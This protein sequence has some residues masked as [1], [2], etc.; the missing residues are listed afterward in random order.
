M[1]LQTVLLSW[2]AVFALTLHAKTTAPEES[3]AR[4]SAL[5]GPLFY[6]ILLGE[7]NARDE[8]PGNA[9]SLLLDAAR[10][11][12]DPELFKRSVRIALQA[13][14]GQSALQAARAW[15]SAMPASQ[16]ANRYLLQILLGLNRVADTLDP[17]KKEI[18]LS[19]IAERRELIWALPSL[20]ERVQDKPAAA[21]LM[22]KALVNALDQPYL[23]ATAWAALG[24]MWQSAGDSA[25]A[26]NAAKEA[27]AQDV[28]SEHAALLALALMNAGVADA[29]AL[30]ERHLPDARSEF[31]MAYVKS[32]LNARREDDARSQ[33][34][35]I[36][37]KSPAYPDAWLVDGA[38]LVQRG[39]T[40]LAEQ[41]LQ[42]YLELTGANADTHAGGDARRGRSQAFLAMAQ[43]AQQRQDLAKAQDW[44]QKVDNPDDVL[45]AQVSRAS[46]MAKQGRIDDAITLIREHVERSEADAKLKR[47]AEVQLLREQ[48]LFARARDTLK[49]FI[50]Q[51][52]S[53]TDLVYQLAMVYEKLGDLA[54]MEHLLRDL[55]AAQPDDPHA[56][57]AL[58]YSLAD[59]NLRL[60]EAIKLI[61][62]ALELAPKDPFITD[63]LAWA[64]FRSGNNEE[65]LRL[66]QQAYGDRQ[67]AEIAAHLGEVLWQMGQ[68][69]A[70]LKIFRES[71]KTA[72]DNATLTD[73]LKRLHVPL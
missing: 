61:T 36:E 16:E 18:S 47:S 26:L 4:I 64:H 60:P 30:V 50:A 62:K 29:E 42:R 56:Y 11:T 41:R 71:Q 17:L 25:A 63:S 8:E 21:A 15:S 58:G 13:R 32:L 45:R 24:R 53:D 40:D 46:L 59:R 48:N 19:P 37:D 72:P 54:E 70:A 28:Q 31:R 44:L 33:L 43:V 5:D 20:Y 3:V 7:L 34:Q 67:D 73:T 49:T 6:Q 23:S 51:F 12:N 14:S 1:R 27:Q 9:F 2:L 22:K 68:H 10:K 55:I 69:D 35:A 57:N 65:A 39:K 66:L 38:L 52:P